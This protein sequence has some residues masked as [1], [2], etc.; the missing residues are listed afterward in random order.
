MS[1]HFPRRFR[2][3]HFSRLPLLPP[4]SACTGFLSG[5]ELFPP[6]RRNS[7]ELSALYTSFTHLGKNLHQENF[8]GP[9]LGD[10]KR[11]LKPYPDF[12]QRSTFGNPRSPHK[13][14]NLTHRPNL[15]GTK[16]NPAMEHLQGN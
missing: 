7:K 5:E 9:F 4:F 14:H 16:Y 15:K 2:Y 11:L 13:T 6:A 1:P 12:K 8:K 10:F 3:P